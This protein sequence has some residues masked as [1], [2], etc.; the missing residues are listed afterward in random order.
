MTLSRY[1]LSFILVVN[2]Y[3][4][5]NIFFYPFKDA[6]DI[7]DMYKEENYT[8]IEIKNQKKKTFYFEDY[9]SFRV[10]CSPSGMKK[11]VSSC[12]LINF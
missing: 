9:S 8:E 1:F 2:I 7:Y 10:N 5:C 12:S 6:V 3:F 11:N 4:T